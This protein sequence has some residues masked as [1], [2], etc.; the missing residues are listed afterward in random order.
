MNVS[1]NV[2]ARNGRIMLVV[3]VTIVVAMGVLVFEGFVR[4]KMGVYLE[5]VEANT[6]QE[7]GA[8]DDRRYPAASFTE[9]PGPRCANEGCKRE[10]RTGTRRTKA[11]LGEKVKTEAKAI[12]GRPT[13]QQR[14]RTP[15]AWKRLM[16]A[17]S[18]DSRNGGPEDA[19]PKHDLSRGQI[20]EWFRQRIVQRP[21]GRRHD[22]GHPS[23][24]DTRAARTSGHNKHRRSR[25]H[26]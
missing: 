16:E 24:T 7:E 14:E 13:R 15:M 9:S 22:H 5:Q 18:Q 20:G 21:S 4:V 23:P 3:V 12:S 1:V 17:K 11:P 2:L 25:D 19:L 26:R 6:G 10:Y 8:R